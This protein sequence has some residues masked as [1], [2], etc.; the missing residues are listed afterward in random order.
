LLA[1]FI[2][3]SLPRRRRRFGWSFRDQLAVR[4]FARSDVEDGVG[5]ERIGEASERAQRHVA[6][7][8][9]ALRNVGPRFPDPTRQIGLRYSLA[10]HQGLDDS[11]GA[12]D[13]P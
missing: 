4:T 13:N 2:A 8:A 10:V 12:L 11:R 7:A 1:F 3:C 6:V 5:I 9:Q